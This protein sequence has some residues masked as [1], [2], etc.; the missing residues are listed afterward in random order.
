MS[1]MNSYEL[2]IFQQTSGHWELRLSADGGT[3][4][5]RVVDGAAI[6]HLIEMVERD[7][8]QDAVAQKV[9]GSRSYV[10]SAQNWPP[11]STATN[12]G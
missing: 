6:D 11:S 2:G 12:G 4:K 10:T 8:S 1:E 9:F 5:T 7:Y 3:P